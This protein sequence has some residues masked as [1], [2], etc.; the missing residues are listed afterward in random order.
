MN[1]TMNQELHEAARRPDP[2]TV[3]TEHVTH[4]YAEAQRLGIT[5]PGPAPRAPWVSDVWLNRSHATTTEAA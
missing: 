5:R 2:V 1:N 4:F 3:M